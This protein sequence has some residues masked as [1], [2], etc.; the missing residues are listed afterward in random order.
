MDLLNPLLSIEWD[1]DYTTLPTGMQHAHA[2]LVGDKVYIGGGM[3]TDPEME[4][5]IYVFD[6]TKRKPKVT[7]IS[8]PG[9]TRW[10]TLATIH[11]KLVLAGGAIRRTSATDKVWVLRDDGSDWDQSV[12]PMLQACW[13]ASAAT[14]G[15]YL[16][17]AGGVES[18]P[19]QPLDTVQIYNASSRQWAFAEP[20]PKSCY[21]MKSVFYDEEWYLAGGRM[22]D[23][24]VFHTSLSPTSP[25]SL[26]ANL[27][28]G[29]DRA[30]NNL[31][32]LSQVC[33]SLSVCRGQLLAVGGQKNT[34]PIR[35]ILAYSAKNRAWIMVEHLPD[36]RETAS[37]IHLP[38]EEILL[39]GG[40]ITD[41]SKYHIYSPK[42]TK[43][44]IKG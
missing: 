31:P 10:S 11:S 20:L 41:L 19:T 38:T 28:G 25:D 24:E 35:E 5:N 22:Q 36:I 29:K 7:P 12:P 26:I 8:T 23:H 37:T 18:R 21:F 3:T 39:I 14:I 44:T 13:G 34:F 17:L 15:D 40:N 6:Y 16:T 2:V 42:I 43:G 32:E 33:S 1:D 30:W 27:E 9:P 4:T